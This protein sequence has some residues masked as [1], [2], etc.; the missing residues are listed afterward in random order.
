MTFA[1]ALCVLVSLLGLAAATRA[2]DV[3]VDRLVE[4]WSDVDATR[5]RIVVLQTQLESSSELGLIDT[6][7]HEILESAL[8]RVRGS[9]DGHEQRLELELD[10]V[11]RLHIDDPDGVADVLMAGAQAYEDEGFDVA[12]HW[13]RGT[14]A[15]LEDRAA[16]APPPASLSERSLD[17]RCALVERFILDR[18]DLAAGLADADGE[19]TYETDAGVRIAIRALVAEPSWGI[20]AAGVAPPD[21]ELTPELFIHLIDLIESWFEAYDASELDHVAEVDDFLRC[22]WSLRAEGVYFPEDHATTLER[23]IATVTGRYSDGEWD[24]ED[25]E[26]LAYVLADLHGDADYDGVW[27]GAE[28]P[29]RYALGGAFDEAR[30][31]TWEIVAETE[32]DDPRRLQRLHTAYLLDS[33]VVVEDDVRGVVADAFDWIA[34]L[35]VQR[36]VIAAG[37]AVPGLEVGAAFDASTGLAI[38]ALLEDAQRHPAVA[39]TGPIDGLF[40]SAFAAHVAGLA[41]SAVDE[42]LVAVLLEVAPALERLTASGI[43][44]TR[45]APKWAEAARTL[46]IGH[47]IAALERIV[48]TVFD[49][50][51]LVVDE[52]WSAA[53]TQGVAWYVEALQHETGFVVDDD[54]RGLYTSAFASHLDAWLVSFDPSDDAVVARDALAYLV[55]AGV[56]DVDR[57]RLRL[58]P[59]PVIVAAEVVP[60][61]DAYAFTT[62]GLPRLDN[63]WAAGVLVTV[64]GF[65]WE[66]G[67]WGVGKWIESK[68]GPAAQRRFEEESRVQLEA[69]MAQYPKFGRLLNMLGVWLSL[70]GAF[71]IWYVRQTG[72]TGMQAFKI[73]AGFEF[74]ESVVA[75]FAERAAFGDVDFFVV[76][77]MTVVSCV[78]TGFTA[79]TMAKNRTP[80]LGIEVVFIG[81]LLV[82]TYFTFITDGTFA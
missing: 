79:Q 46:F 47:H 82:V 60:T 27:A 13:L 75:F 7:T 64:N 74:V 28:P 51:G 5:E 80:V 1:R 36:L 40:T 52:T 16:L 81:L 57:E 56:Y 66:L 63:A 31:R 26:A 62:A 24:V 54:D 22:L 34:L 35:D 37:Y 65:V 44:D 55:A 6:T 41:R 18:H 68:H 29:G 12:A 77:T 3:D 45:D 59:P 78:I 25:V 72:A 48:A 23:L 4:R 67:S 71:A 69:F 42:P 49:V 43:Y 10:R 9:L 21:G 8:E 73:G 61:D 17:Q 20:A 2:Q 15:I 19:W 14:L 50:P 33:L 11:E 39:W 30:L 32:R 38:S 76:F 70:G 58:T 53:T